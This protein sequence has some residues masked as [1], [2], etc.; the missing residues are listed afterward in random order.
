[1]VAG[2]VHYVSD[3]LETYTPPYY[4]VHISISTILITGSKYRER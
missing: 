1:M 2:T 3:G 4:Q